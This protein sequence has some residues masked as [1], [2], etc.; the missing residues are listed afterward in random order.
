[1]IRALKH[2]L[3]F[4]GLLLMMQIAACNE[5]DNPDPEP[6]EEII[7]STDLTSLNFDA[8]G[9]TQ[10]L[11]ITSNV[12]WTLEY[13]SNSWARSSLQSTKGNASVQI[14]AD[15]NETTESREM[16][17]TLSADG[18]ESISIN[19]SQEPGEE[20]VVV[21]EPDLEDYIDPDNTDMRNLTSFELA[22]EMGVG[23]NL[24]NSLEAM[25]SNN[26]VL[27]GN[28]TS[29]GNPV[30]TKQ[31]IDSIKAAGFNTIRLPV[32]WSHQFDDEETFDISYEWKLRVEEVVNYA[33]DNDMYVM[34]NIHWDGGWLNDPVYEKQEE[35]ND[36]LEI[37]WKQ[38]AKFFRDYDDHLLFAGTNEVLLEGDYGTPTAE[39]VEV[40]NS[41]NQTFINTVRATG[42]RNA[43]RHLV[44]QT[45]NT[46]IS[47]GINY[48]EVPEDE[49][50]DRMMVEVH[51]YDPY[52]FTLDANSG[53]YLWGEANAGSVAHSDWGDEDWVDDIFGQV[54]THFVNGGYPVILGEYAASLR[55]NLSED[56][57]AKHIE[58]RNYYLNYVT[59]TALKNDMV[60]VYW[61]NGHTGDTGS[62][63]FN[64]ADGS[65]AHPDA[66]EAIIS[67]KE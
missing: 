58:S 48:F 29:W 38:I 15:K 33:L 59:K 13:T 67:A 1:M 10:S 61:D 50:E 46:N 64:R 57:Y 41:F 11:V 27:S 31:L 63:L 39:Y 34:M 17:F 14:T 4:A 52:Q 53:V 24:G 21:V 42:G 28:E 19:V 60:P 2:L 6:E 7:L 18:A 3:I 65:K 56:A 37:M 9:G 40:Q 32:A 26:G 20:E 22:A 5:G 45:F 47:H 49:I 36:R 35:L 51:F 55:T 44:V 66:L 8:D 30:I 43:Y 23:W 16:T 54:L 62:G 25:L 12:I